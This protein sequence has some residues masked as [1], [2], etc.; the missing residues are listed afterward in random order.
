MTSAAIKQ[1]LESIAS[2]G[3]I[4]PAAV[5]ERASDPDSALHSHFTWD[6]TEAGHKWRMEEARRL[7]RVFVITS[8]A[9]DGQPVRAFISLTTDRQGGGGYRALASVLDDEDMREQLLAD[10][11]QEFRYF[12]QKYERV[13]ELEPLFAAARKIKK[14][15]RAVRSEAVQTAGV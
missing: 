12:Q 7:L 15:P 1:E 8:A 9:P 13:K 10:A 5:V 3:L 6:D 11:L 4:T 2:G 14:K